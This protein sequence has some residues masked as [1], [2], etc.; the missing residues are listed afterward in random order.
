MQPFL[1]AFILMRRPARDRLGRLG[2]VGLWEAA[3]AGSACR[4]AAVFLLG[5]G[6]IGAA[7]AAGYRSG[8]GLAA[9]AA[10]VRDDT[11]CLGCH[12]EAARDSAAPTISGDELLGSTHATLVCVDCHRDVKTAPHS[13]QLAP[14]DCARCHEPPPGGAK[15]GEAPASRHSRAARQ[16]SAKL[17]RCPDCH[18][19]HG[20]PPAIGASPGEARVLVGRCAECHAGESHEY[21]ESVHGEELARGNPDVPVCASCHP[22]H[23]HRAATERSGVLEAGVVATCVSCHDDPGLQEQYALPGNRLASYLGSY[24]GTARQLGD[25]R[26]ANCV[27]C[28]GYHDI[29]PSR[30]PRSATNPK[31]L[32]RTC[33]GCHPGVTENVAKGQV[34]VLATKEGTALLYYINLGFRWFTFAIIGALVGHIGLEL[35]GRW[36]GRRGD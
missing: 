1:K 16:T 14:V 33:G 27:S 30:D 5:T 20:T 23:L 31:N 17:P 6:C 35:L 36:R 3:R 28:H 13:R 10:V 25:T 4:W 18:G 11:V 7:A 22:E 26:T 12:G 2:N 15:K 29:L 24:H 19:E 9:S 32:E 21:W 34:H 8:E